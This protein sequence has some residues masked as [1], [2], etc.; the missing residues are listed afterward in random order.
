M[1]E[2]FTNYVLLFII[3]SFAGW[4]IEVINFEIREHKFVDRGFLIGPWLPIYGTGAI[5]MINFLSKYSNDLIT[6]FCMCVVTCSLLEYLTSYIME[7]IFKAR[8][9]DYGKRRFNINGRI[10]LETASLFGLGGCIVIRLINPVIANLLSLI[11]LNVKFII[12]LILFIL[13]IIDFL[14]SF[15]VIISFRTITS[16]I[17]KDSTIEISKKVKETLESSS[18]LDK[19]LINAFPNFEATLRSLQRKRFSF[20]KRK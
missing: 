10:C 6:L 18:I 19:R 8:W 14:V 20:F 15:K 17:H 2:I 9:W 4:I 7:K 3:Y 11:S 12:A 1:K 13:F 5:L 16:K